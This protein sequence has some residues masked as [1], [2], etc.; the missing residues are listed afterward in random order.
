MIQP[1]IL[2]I[3]QSVLAAPRQSH[4]T[5]FYY[6]FSSE[7]EGVDYQNG[8]IVLAAIFA[9]ILFFWA[10]LLIAFKC[11]GNS[12]GCASGLAFREDE[13]TTEEDM[14]SPP[15]GG[16]STY[17]E[18]DLSSSV[19]SVR[20]DQNQQVDGEGAIP[21]KEADDSSFQSSLPSDTDSAF[22]G[23]LEEYSVGESAM[24]LPN[25]RARR[26]RI[27][28]V[29][30]SLITLACIPLALV[31]AFIPVRDTVEVSGVYV[32]S[33]RVIVDEVRTAI[34]TINSA[35]NSSFEI[36]QATPLNFSA[37]CPQ[38]AQT[39]GGSVLGVDLNAMVQILVKDYS[40]VEEV[41]SKNVTEIS[42]ILNYIEEALDIFETSYEEVETYI[43]LIPGILIG[44]S[45][46]TVLAMAAVV[47]AWK[48]ES[49]RRTQRLVS[50]GILPLF[51]VLSITCWIIAISTAISTAVSNDACNPASGSPDD[52]IQAILAARDVSPNS[53][54]SEF[55]TAY[56]GGCSGEDPTSV[57]LDLKY[58]LQTIVDYIWRSLSAVESAGRAE[59]VEM[60]GGGELEGFL[61]NAQELARILTTVRKQIDSATLS[62]DCDRI[63][64]LYIDAVHESLCTDIAGA[65]GWGFVIFFVLGLSTMSMISLRASWRHKIGEERIYDESEVADNMIMDEHEDY[66]NYISKYK[67]EWQEYKGIDPSLR[68]QNRSTN[69]VD[70]SASESEHSTGSRTEG[71]SGDEAAAE[72]FDPYNCS[73]TDNQ[74]AATVASEDI[75]FLSLSDGPPPGDMLVLL[76]PPLLPRV[77]NDSGVFEAVSTHS[78]APGHGRSQLNNVVFAQA[79]PVG[80]A[81]TSF[82]FDEA[83]PSGS[84]SLFE[85]HDSI[86]IVA[87]HKSSR[88]ASYVM[89]PSPTHQTRKRHSIKDG[90]TRPPTSPTRQS[91]ARL[92][93]SNESDYPVMGSLGN[94]VS[95]LDPPVRHFLFDRDDGAV[96]FDVSDDD[97]PAS[98]V[99]RQVENFTR[100]KVVRPSTPTKSREP[101]QVKERVARFDSP[102]REPDTR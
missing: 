94:A 95:L 96:Q 30:L 80:G 69:E 56:T 66:L 16:G 25:P 67:H 59:I 55:I 87:P 99:Q 84:V 23:S 62:L 65:S 58:Q 31:F 8:L 97:E 88:S 73:D 72:P 79:V 33:A 15:S 92:L 1:K 17:L 77:A 64:P 19:N 100:S 26:T 6:L 48:R 39:E 45:S 5:S 70:E 24:Q 75:S 60:C 57:L 20:G 49:S 42:R 50:Y 74:S 43:W 18:E 11:T 21:A 86:E 29:V 91:S 22:A 51:I 53:T 28:F 68:D 83:N 98:H 82:N 85:L 10:A 7:E 93:A 46:L 14:E 27:A 41:V 52:T 4:S 2:S 40:E 63:N 76:P 38:V 54:V 90:S 78:P 89:T 35:A 47:M 32:G 102:Y 9:S 36:M 12:A 3:L 81:S 37:I 34:S 61:A 71:Q 13:G 44:L 101:A